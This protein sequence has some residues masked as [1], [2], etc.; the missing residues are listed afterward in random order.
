MTQEETNRILTIITEVYPSFRKDRDPALT[1]QLWHEIFRNVSYEQVKRSLMEFITTDAKG[2]PPAPGSL[3]ALIRSRMEAEELSE[4]EAL[5]IT[6]KAISRGIYYS[7]EEFDK[8]PRSV[9]AVVR[10]PE[11]LHEWASMDEWEVRNSVIPW[12]FRAYSSQI[13]NGLQE[14]LFPAEESPLLP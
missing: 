11:K 10:S 9:Q 5:E 3:F 6:R 12:F 2:F 7:R 4:A 8:L 14:R 1:S 13:K